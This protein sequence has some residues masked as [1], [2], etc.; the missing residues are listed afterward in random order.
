MFIL[1]MNGTNGEISGIFSDHVATFSGRR[2]TSLKVSK[3]GGVYFIVSYTV[4]EY[5][6]M[7][8]VISIYESDM[9]LGGVVFRA[10]S[11]TKHSNVEIDNNVDIFSDVKSLSPYST[12]PYNKNGDE[13]DHDDNYTRCIRYIATASN[14]ISD[15]L[16]FDVTNLSSTEWFK[17]VYNAHSREDT[18][19]YMGT[20]KIALFI[21]NI[22]ITS[23]DSG[24]SNE[25][26][27]LSWTNSGNHNITL[28]IPPNSNATDLINILNADIVFNAD[29][30]ASIHTVNSKSFLKIISVD[31][32]DWVEGMYLPWVGLN[33]KV[34][35]P[36]EVVLTIPPTVINSGV[37]NIITL[38]GVDVDISITSG[39]SL[40]TVIDKI[41]NSL[42]LG[43]IKMRVAGWGIHVDL[44]SI[45]PKTLADINIYNEIVGPLSWG[46]SARVNAHNYFYNNMLDRDTSNVTN[47]TFVTSGDYWSSSVGDTPVIFINPINSAHGNITNFNKAEATQINHS[48]NSLTSLHNSNGSLELVDGDSIDFEIKSNMYY[49]SSNIYYLDNVR[50]LIPLSSDFEPNSLGVDMIKFSNVMMMAEDHYR[51]GVSDFIFTRNV[52]T[53]M[54]NKS[55]V[56]HVKHVAVGADVFEFKIYSTL[57]GPHETR[58]MQQSI[59][60]SQTNN[61]LSIKKISKSFINEDDVFTNTEESGS[62]L[63]HE[64]NDVINKIKTHIS[65]NADMFNH[66]ESSIMGDRVNNRNTSFSIGYNRK[67]FVE[68]F[69]S[70]TF[71][72]GN[73][74]IVSVNMFNSKDISMFNMCGYVKYAPFLDGDIMT[75]IFTQR[76]NNK[77]KSLNLGVVAHAASVGAN[78][79]INVQ[80]KKHINSNMFVSTPGTNMVYFWNSSL[81]KYDNVYTDLSSSI[82]LHMLDGYCI[83]LNSSDFS[84]IID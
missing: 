5:N 84:S 45:T 63:S 76:Y 34:T 42:G 74:D 12:S 21:G 77:E 16:N 59:R 79:K 37:I 57:N 69:P 67:N 4:E 26:F 36:D 66:L 25:E 62:V 23:L 17:R 14:S 8:D 70:I 30:V 32:V 28:T 72:N 61:V 7:K 9:L 27:K 51:S 65:Q 33:S 43:F 24:S 56:Q 41:I 64:M 48:G 2:V 11:F 29:L 46:V 44:C 52:F 10:S 71:N 38:D 19:I 22:D 20:S 31:T 82:I 54:F 55:H 13:R 1:S 83:E 40:A 60:F 78:I 35:T 73:I 18:G 58:C 15:P 81:Q 68:S 80:D 6:V 53:Y 75:H 47:A 50:S 49:E 39:D 3:S